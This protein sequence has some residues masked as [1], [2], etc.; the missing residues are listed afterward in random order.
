M[1]KIKTTIMLAGIL[2][3]AASLSACDNSK[4]N[5]VDS[6]QTT[7]T[8]PKQNN[9]AKTMS[10]ATS[11]KQAVSDFKI[12]EGVNY[13]VLQNPLDI[14]KTNDLVISEFFWLGCGHCQRFDPLVKQWDKELSKKGGVQVFKT[15]A[16]GSLDV[17]KDGSI[18]GDRWT[19]DAR[20]FNALK[21]MGGTSADVSKMLNLYKEKAM[22]TRMQPTTED[23]ISYFTL[24]G[25][26]G[27]KA[28]E[29]MKDNKT[30]LPLLE[31]ANVEF[32]KTGAQGTPVFVVDGKYKVMFNEDIKSEADIISLFEQLHNLDK[33][34]KDLLKQ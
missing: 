23:V 10:T 1:K 20:V 8:A 28:F 27:N 21:L 4:T 33:P 26:D 14:P 3:M 7:L 30:M 25:F 9:D 5:N 11:E 19:Y 17:P 22:Q 29:L 32:N 12:K 2:S 13:T 6:K 34:Q 15:A 31:K 16:T 18:E 24:L